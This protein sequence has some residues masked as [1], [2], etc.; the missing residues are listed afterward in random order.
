MD[1]LLL[2]T[3]DDPAELAAQGYS[4]SWKLNAKRAIGC[5]YVIICALGKGTG[6]LVGKVRGLMRS[7]EPTRFDVYISEYAELDEANVWTTASQ[8]PVGYTSAKELSFD[9]GEL[10]FKPV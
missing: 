2:N 5:D 1:I 9:L 3:G 8:N 4:G 6:V 7:E 10:N